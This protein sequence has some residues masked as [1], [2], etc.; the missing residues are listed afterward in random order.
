MSAKGR[1]SRCLRAR[2]RAT[3]R[4]VAG[5]ARQ[6]IAAQALDRDDLAVE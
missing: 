3:G 5:A 1:S 4:L 6:V 2:S